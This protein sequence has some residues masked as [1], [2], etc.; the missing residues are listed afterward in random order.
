MGSSGQRRVHGSKMCLTPGKHGGGGSWTSSAKKRKAPESW[1]SGG[2]VVVGGGGGASW[3]PDP[4][5]GWVDPPKLEVIKL[6][7]DSSLVQLGLPDAGIGLLWSKKN[8]WFYYNTERIFKD[9]IQN[10]D[11]VSIQDDPDW[12]MLPEIAAALTPSG[13]EENSYSVA[14][15]TVPYC[16]GVG[17]SASPA[18]R[19]TAAKMALSIRV[20]HALGKTEELAKK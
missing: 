13:V 19:E 9:V 8:G 10:P 6:A 3:S 7:A 15:S 14:I 2:G 18:G 4:S 1:L 12:K 5:K 16:W 20:M 17:L 11:L